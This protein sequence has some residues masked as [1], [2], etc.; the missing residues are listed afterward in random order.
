MPGGP[1]PRDAKT[2][3]GGCGAWAEP[4][5]ETGGPSPPRR[6]AREKA[7]TCRR[8]RRPSPPGAPAESGPGE[9]AGFRGPSSPPASSPLLPR[10]LSLSSCCSAGACRYPPRAPKLFQPRFRSPRNWKPDTRPATAG[11]GQRGDCAPP[12]GARPERRRPRPGAPARP[13]P[14]PAQP[15]APAGGAG[16]GPSP[17]SAWEMP[18]ALHC[19]PAESRGRARSAA[20]PHLPRWLGREC[21]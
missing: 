14:R 18:P 17:T 4:W 11:Q 21:V 19:P 3:T 16:R 12:S 15:S 9:G 6:G 2:D 5:P 1:N 8:A 13:H 20:H 10:P 7:L